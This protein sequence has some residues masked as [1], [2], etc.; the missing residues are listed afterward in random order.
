MKLFA[1]HCFTMILLVLFLPL[2]S[3]LECYSCGVFLSALTK[4][5]RGQPDIL[6]CTNMAFPP[7]C[8]TIT[9]ENVD[10]TFYVEKRCGTSEDV[11]VKD[12]ECIDISLAKT[13]NAKKCLC[14]S[15]L[16]NAAD[17][18]QNKY[19]LLLTVCLSITLFLLFS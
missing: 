18:Q 12:G 8:V 17:L 14:K 13:T 1:S 3:S 7:G 10:G 5:C 9:G 15:N 19:R 11:N 16:C 4:N 2:A 6:N